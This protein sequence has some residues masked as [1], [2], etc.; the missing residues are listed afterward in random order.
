MRNHLVIELRRHFA[1]LDS[2]T[3]EWDA[4]SHFRHTIS[5]HDLYGKQRVI[6]KSYTSYRESWQQLVP[7]K[8]RAELVVITV[9][10]LDRVLG[11]DEEGDLGHP[12]PTF[13]V[14]PSPAGMILDP[15]EER[16]YLEQDSLYGSRKEYFAV[17]EKRIHF[18]KK[19]RF[20]E[21]PE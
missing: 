9:I 6:D 7:E 11:I 10:P 1:Y 20:K 4:L 5:R 17:A 21:K 13:Y 18:F 3:G 2:E 12:L 14:N 15:I 19:F 8:K 16:Y